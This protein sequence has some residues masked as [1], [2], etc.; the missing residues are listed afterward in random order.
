MRLS[1]TGNSTKRLH[2]SC[3]PPTKEHNGRKATRRSAAT[4]GSTIRAAA[5]RTIAAVTCANAAVKP[6]DA[7]RPTRHRPTSMKSAGTISASSDAPQPGSLAKAVAAARPTR[8][9]ARH[10][11]R[12]SFRGR[13]RQPRVSRAQ[14]P[15]MCSRASTSARGGTKSSTSTATSVGNRKPKWPINW[16]AAATG[17]SGG[18]RRPRSSSAAPQGSGAISRSSSSKTCASS[19]KRASAM[20]GWACETRR[21][22]ST[23]RARK[24]PSCP[25]IPLVV[26][27]ST[28]RSKC[29]SSSLSAISPRSRA[30]EFVTNAPRA[31]SSEV[32][33]TSSRLTR[34]ASFRARGAMSSSI[35]I[36][37]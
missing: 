22:A 12:T 17:G 2:V 14:A 10:V 32:S 5:L 21:R 15:T 3:P 1:Q 11:A 26:H 25:C 34:T 16:S 36:A 13:P 37:R 35:P 24:A 8:P 20:S 30:M 6:S 27:T 33:I 23:S 4:H 18:F 9:G 28:T 29:T 7:P 19:G 31:S